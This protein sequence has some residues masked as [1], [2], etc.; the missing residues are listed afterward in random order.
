MILGILGFIISGIGILLYCTRTN[1]FLFHPGMKYYST[2]KL[3][4]F[5]LILGS[6]F[7]MYNILEGFF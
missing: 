2:T 5:L 1:T 3:E 7:I 4:G 6:L